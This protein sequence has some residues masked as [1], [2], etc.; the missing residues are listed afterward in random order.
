MTRRAIAATLLLALILG[1]CRA[2]AGD[3]INA[4]IRP[5]SAAD[6]MLTRL[7]AVEVLSIHQLS[8]GRKWFGGISGMTFDGHTVTAINDVGHW[9]RFHMEVDGDGRPVS[10]SN[11]EVAAL[12]G[13]DGS[14]EDGDAEEV[15]AIPG[16]WL[17]SFERRH[18]VLRYGS[19]LSGPPESLDMP[20]GYADQPENGGVEAMTS[21][22]DGRL[23]LISEEGTGADGLGQAWI[24]RPGEWRTLSYRRQGQFHP[25]SAALLPNGDVLVL[26]RR[27]S[28]IGGV[29]SRLVRVAAAD[30]RPG[31]VLEGREL[32]TVEP[33]LL[34]DNYEGLAV[35]PRQDGRLV[36]Y[37]VADDNFNVL[38]ATL[39]MA[40]LL[41]D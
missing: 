24:G 25:T 20:P 5:L 15:R 40:V 18:R 34:V 17:V 36:A 4:E 30:L 13:L 27:F 32:F 10:F 41:P 39:L 14:K 29:A 16:G 37:L 35:R 38:Q 28:L 7:G 23:L 19:D 9:L 6:P 8:S 21:L 31:A 11:L 2:P 26:E 3:G 1:G 22:A 33:P 12:G